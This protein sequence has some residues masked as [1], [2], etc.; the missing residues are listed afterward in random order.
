MDTDIPRPAGG[1]PHKWPWFTTPVGGHFTMYAKNVESIRSTLARARRL[2]RVDFRLERRTGPAR[3]L[4][5]RV[6]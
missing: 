5:R 3:Y 2:Y 6:S 4:V 1:R